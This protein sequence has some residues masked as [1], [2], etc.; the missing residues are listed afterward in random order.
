MPI[1]HFYPQP[2]GNKE[3]ISSKIGEFILPLPG[4]IKYYLVI[5]GYWRKSPPN[6]GIEKG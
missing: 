2:S 3:K 4:N 6:L 5:T 1:I